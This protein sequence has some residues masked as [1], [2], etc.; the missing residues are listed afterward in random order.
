MEFSLVS[1][2]RVHVMKLFIMHFS[3]ISY[4]FSLFQPYSA[5]HFQTPTVNVLPKMSE[6]KL[7]SHMKPQAELCTLYP[8]FYGFRQKTGRQEILG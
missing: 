2:R 1:F 3:P 8:N 7:H 5:A 6:T 4:D